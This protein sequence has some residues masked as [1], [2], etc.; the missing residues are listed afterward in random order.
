MSVGLGGIGLGIYIALELDADKFIQ[1]HFSDVVA[2]NFDTHELE[3]CFDS[4]AR[5]PCRLVLF[6][7]MHNG[8]GNG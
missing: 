8:P 1:S 4:I 2:F 3:I 5:K 7:R 6:R